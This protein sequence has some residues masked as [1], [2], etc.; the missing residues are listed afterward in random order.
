MM[1]ILVVDWDGLGFKLIQ[2]KI[3]VKDGLGIKLSYC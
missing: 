1:P 3:Q 2:V